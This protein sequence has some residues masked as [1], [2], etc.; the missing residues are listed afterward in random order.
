MGMEKQ[1]TG[2]KEQRTDME[3]LWKS[4]GGNG[5]GK[6]KHLTEVRR[7]GGQAEKGKG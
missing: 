3:W 4:R 2:R 5:I 7:G 1:G 6:E